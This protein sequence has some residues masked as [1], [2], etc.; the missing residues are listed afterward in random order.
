MSDSGGVCI[1]RWLGLT[2]WCMAVG[3]CVVHVSGS[4]AVVLAFVT[5]L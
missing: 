4:V 3:L 5:D 1:L 2:S